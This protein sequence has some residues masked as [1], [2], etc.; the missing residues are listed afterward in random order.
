M[1]KNKK[2]AVTRGIVNK[3]VCGFRSAVTRTKLCC[4]LTGEQSAIP[5]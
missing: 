2:H 3:G 4:N 1:T 5:Y